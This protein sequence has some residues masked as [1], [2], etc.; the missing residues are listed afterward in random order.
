LSSGFKAIKN[1][2]EILLQQAKEMIELMTSVKD[3]PEGADL[4]NKMSTLV[5]KL[6]KHAKDAKTR[7]TLLQ[8]L[9]NEEEHLKEKV[10][11]ME[12]EQV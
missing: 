2:S 4:T 11:A 3:K 6:G 7:E 8:G 12:I 9:A 1:Q 10:V 5:Q